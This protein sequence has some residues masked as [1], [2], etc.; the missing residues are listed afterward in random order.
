MSRRVARVARGGQT[1]G[2]CGTKERSGWRGG[3]G[4]GVARAVERRGGTSS[5]DGGGCAGGAR[6]GRKWPMTGAAWLQ[7]ADGWSGHRR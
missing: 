3:V 6:G 7:V 4:G 2:Q 5:R 1:A